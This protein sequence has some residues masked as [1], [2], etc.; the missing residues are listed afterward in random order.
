MISWSSGQARMQFEEYDVRKNDET[1]PALIVLH[2]LT[3]I[4]LKASYE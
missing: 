1:S 4:L 2:F 3:C